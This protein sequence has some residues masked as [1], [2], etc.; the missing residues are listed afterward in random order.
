MARKRNYRGQSYGFLRFLNVRN[1]DKLAIALNNVWIGQYRIWAREAR[2]DRH[3]PDSAEVRGDGRKKEGEG[4]AVVRVRG[5]GIRNIRVGKKTYEGDKVLERNVEDREE[6]DV[7]KKVEEVAPAAMERVGGGNVVV[8]R[9]EDL[10]ASV[11]GVKED[12]LGSVLV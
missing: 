12:R 5:E 2:F 11:L 6:R 9:R 10:K 4:K 3:A 8:V 1:R 7:G